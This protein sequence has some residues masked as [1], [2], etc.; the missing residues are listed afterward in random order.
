[1]DS[2]ELLT[3]TESSKYRVGQVWQYK[4]RVGEE[5]STFTV[6]KVE[7]QYAKTVVVHIAVSNIKL[8]LPGEGPEKES[9]ISHI[10]F[11][12][13]ALDASVLT[14][15]DAVVDLPAFEEGYETW[16]SA[17]LDGQAGMFS[18]E[19]AQAVNFMEK[20]LNSDE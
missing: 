16:R 2:L 3:D 9:E 18:V 4:N 12:E 11:S 15:L 19:V 14:L 8:S 1:M 13:E 20:A 6:V 10:P 5:D 17:F 7:L